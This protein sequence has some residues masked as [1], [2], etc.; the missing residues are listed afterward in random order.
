MH[1]TSNTRPSPDF[2]PTSLET[3]LSGVV[4]CSMDAPPSICSNEQRRATTTH[5]EDTSSYSPLSGA[6]SSAPSGDQPML[7]AS[8]NNSDSQSQSMDEGRPQSGARRV[9]TRTDIDSDGTAGRAE[10]DSR[11]S[12]KRRAHQ[13]EQVKP[14]A[15][16]L[17]NDEELSL[18]MEEVI[19]MKPSKVE[20]NLIDKTLKAVKSK[21][22]WVYDREAATKT[23]QEI[24]AAA[25]RLNVQPTPDADELQE[26]EQ[27]EEVLNDQLDISIETMPEQRFF[28]RP[29]C[30][31]RRAYTGCAVRGLL[32]MMC[33]V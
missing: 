19:P 10:D 8:D 3:Y 25:A 29:A 23:V 22:N 13:R 5:G 20:A 11:R 28:V 4:A 6:P 2:A 1:T 9:R 21:E 18:L 33:A 16:D 27:R 31:V 26:A 14:A 30:K 12:S 24:E 15:S 7:F 32:T 17:L